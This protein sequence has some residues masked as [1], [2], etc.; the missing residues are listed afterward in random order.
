M[1]LIDTTQLDE[2]LRADFDAGLVYWKRSR[3]GINTKRPVGCL[4][5][6]GYVKFQFQ[7]KSTYVHRVIWAL[8][9]KQ[10]PELM[11]DHI[12]GVR[13]DNRLCNLRLA[14]ASMNA[15]NGGLFSTNTTGVRGVS[16]TPFGKYKVTKCSKFLGNYD[17]LMEAER[18]YNQYT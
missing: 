4:D 13:N 1:L 6:N 14:T 18:A 7:Y 2:N 11:I 3:R 12:N 9:Y 15:L 5:S 17:T 10:W 8:Y 16:M